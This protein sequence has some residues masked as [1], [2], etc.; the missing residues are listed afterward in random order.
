MDKWQPIETAPKEVWQKSKHV[1]CCHAEKRWTR[2]GR[3]YGEL[4][5]WYY[6]GTSERTQWA[7][8]VGDAPTHWMPFPELPPATTGAT[9]ER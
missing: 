5:R 4:G 7:E 9:N 1:L 2:F 8:T 3:Y 6:S